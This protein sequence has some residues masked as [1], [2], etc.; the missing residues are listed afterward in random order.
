MSKKKKS[1]KDSQRPNFRSHPVVSHTLVVAATIASCIGLMTL[2][3]NSIC[4]AKDASIQQLR[5]GLNVERNL[6]AERLEIQ[7]EKYAETL[8]RAKRV[9]AELE[10]TRSKLRKTE[11]ELANITSTLGESSHRE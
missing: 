7:R 4:I 11:T 3:L 5:I 9:E 6:H 1:T 8:S 10:V 2:I